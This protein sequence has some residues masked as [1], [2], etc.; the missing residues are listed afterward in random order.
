MA[1]GPAQAITNVVPTL[2]W[3]KASG[4]ASMIRFVALQPVQ[5]PGTT[6]RGPIATSSSMVRGMMASNR[7][8]VRWKPPMKA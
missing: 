5:C 7:P 2:V 8:P 1:E 3:R 4:M 6:S